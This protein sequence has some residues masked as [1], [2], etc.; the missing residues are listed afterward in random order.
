[1]PI[2]N[3]ANKGYGVSSNATYSTGRSANA[4]FAFNSQ[5]GDSTY[6]AG[7]RAV[8]AR[9]GGV[10]HTFYR[11]FFRFD[12]SGISSAPSAATITINGHTGF[13]ATGNLR[14]VKGTFANNSTCA[15][16]DFGSYVSLNTAY[17]NEITSWSTGDNDITLNT[18]ALNDMASL[19]HFI[20]FLVHET[21]D[22]DNTAGSGGYN[23]VYGEAL[24]PQYLLITQQQSLDQ[25]IYQHLEELLKII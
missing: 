13:G 6:A 3:S 7:Y 5:N 8:S 16:T 17:S 24:D 14:L 18:A 9:G 12:T 10:T 2:I 15:T 20:L 4:T 11:S 25:Q 23:G 19:S 1:M 22:Y 21:Y